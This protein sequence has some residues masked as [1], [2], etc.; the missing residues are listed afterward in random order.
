MLEIWNEKY[1]FVLCIA[2]LCPGQNNW[3]LG[4][5]KILC[6]RVEHEWEK[7]IPIIRNLMTQ[8]FEMTQVEK[9]WK[10]RTSSDLIPNDFVMYLYTRAWTYNRFSKCWLIKSNI[11]TFLCVLSYQRKYGNDVP[12]KA[13]F[14]QLFFTYLSKNIIQWLS[15]PI[16]STAAAAS[17]SAFLSL[18]R[19]VAG[20]VSWFPALVAARIHC[21][22][23]HHLRIAP[24]FLPDSRETNVHCHR[25]CSTCG[26]R[27]LVQGNLSTYVL[28]FHLWIKQFPETE[29][30]IVDFVG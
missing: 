4:I 30:W 13:I 10:T 24:V 19:A 11:V 28:A 25:S 15:L 2:N 21:S 9:D 12:I 6:H 27:F 3:N 29:Y 17:L 8:R 5:L 26:R 14:F 22:H 20:H 18:I 16:K 23:S 1:H 7:N